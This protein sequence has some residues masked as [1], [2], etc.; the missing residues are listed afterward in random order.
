MKSGSP[1]VF[2]EVFHTAMPHSTSPV[3]YSNM[4]WAQ[5]LSAD[6]KVRSR[7]PGPERYIERNA[8]VDKSGGKVQASE[9][10]AK[11]TH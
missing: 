10:A 11:R 3:G 4:R 5:G 6:I 2:P 9:Q 7:Q 1:R 8:P